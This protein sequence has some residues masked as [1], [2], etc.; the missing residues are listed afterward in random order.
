[1]LLFS[2]QLHWLLHR[3]RLQRGCSLTRRTEH[4]MLQHFAS[5][6]R[7]LVEIGVFEDITSRVLREAMASDGK[8]WCIDP[9]PCGRLGFS[10][11][12]SIARNEANRC[13]KG[14]VE[15]LRELSHDAALGWR[16][17]LDFIFIDGDHTY[18][19]VVQD[20][21]DWSPHVVT[22]GIVA[23]HDS[24]TQKYPGP[25]RLV[26]EITA[27]AEDY[28]IVGEVDTLTVFEKTK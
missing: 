11:R 28:Q 22:G 6:K 21:K 16:E 18:D 19:A 13:R 7:R 20:W 24:R 26:H 10:Y 15:F 5:G 8:L 1:M 23:F 17:P 14:T 2:I 12:Y 9:F 4:A 27:G 25:L 3:L